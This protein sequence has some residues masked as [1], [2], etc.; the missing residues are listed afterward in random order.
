ME[1]DNI[2]RHLGV[3]D[4]GERL[5][6][7]VT[8]KI[9]T[10]FHRTTHQTNVNLKLANLKKDNLLWFLANLNRLKT[11][12]KG[13]GDYDHSL[14]TYSQKQFP[15]VDLLEMT[16][17][18]M[19]TLIKKAEDNPSTL[20][21]SI[22]D[23]LKEF[24]KNNPNNSNLQT[25]LNP[26]IFYINSFTKICGDEGISRR[27]N[28]LEEPP[29]QDLR[30]PPNATYVGLRAKADSNFIKLE[31]QYSKLSKFLMA[32]MGYVSLN[33]SSL[34]KDLREKVGHHEF[35]AYVSLVLKIQKTLESIG[36]KMGYDGSQAILNSGSA[37]EAQKG[38]NIISN[39]I[40]TRMSPGGKNIFD[41]KVWSEIPEIS[42][43][44]LENYALIGMTIKKNSPN[45]YSGFL[46]A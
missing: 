6:V 27:S 46:N 45:V 42:Q 8:R 17:P 26:L 32:T 10:D 12:L 14:I 40:G 43:R 39:A 24:Y 41:E 34:L 16:Q 33:E 21:R 19:E 38:L 31:N 35:K 28:T 18:F 9:T 22:D 36:S 20:N 25:Y 29:G 1:A 23:A 37:Q 30:T 7:S 5:E 2:K 15:I 11:F 13:T 4:N 3:S 44:E